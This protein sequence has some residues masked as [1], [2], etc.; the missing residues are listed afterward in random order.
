MTHAV[1]IGGGVAGPAAA[2][3]LQQAGIE[4]TVHEAYPTGADDVGAFLNLMA[5]GIDALAA[6]GADQLVI[7]HS[8]PA[9]RVEFL[10]GSGRPLGAVPITGTARTLT[11]AALY[12]LL[13]DEATP[14]GITIHHGKRLIGLSHSGDTHVTARFADNTDTQTD[15]LIG[16]DGVHS[17]TRGLIDPAAPAPRYLDMITVCGYTH[18]SP[19]TTPVGT[20]RM[21]YGRRAFA[22]YTTDPDGTTWWFVTIPSRERSRTELAATTSQQW[23]RHLLELLAR[24]HTPL[25]SIVA[26]CDSTIIGTGAYDIPHLPT[27]HHHHAIVLGDAAHAASPSAGHG[28]SLALEDAVILAQCLRDLPAIPEAL[29][30]FEHLRRSRAEQLVATSAKMTGRAI[31]GPLTRRVRDALLPLLLRGGPRN[32]SAWL[33]SHHIDWHIPVTDTTSSATTTE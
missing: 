14:R 26:A 15:L 31:P 24:D 3:A 16:A 10:A 18:H 32:T 2:M 22:G 23:K 7:D 1:I 5:N 33:T 29:A 30:T 17:T 4:A 9:E 20:Y 13:H 21:A 25:A 19:E 8:L 28:A 11:R 12:R 27:W 6:I